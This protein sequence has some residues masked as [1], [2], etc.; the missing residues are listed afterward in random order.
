MTR[1]RI[2]NLILAMGI[3]GAAALG[4]GCAP[5]TLRLAPDHP[6]RPDAPAG[7]AADPA[8]I[9]G[10][11]AALYQAAGAAP[12]D[13][14]LGTPDGTREHPYVGR[15][16]IRE[17]REGFVVIQHGAIPGLMGAMTMTFPVAREVDGGRLVPGDEVRFFIEMREPGGPRIFRVE[18]I[19]ADATEQEDPHQ[20]DAPDS[21][22]TATGT[23][24]PG[25][26]SE[27]CARQAP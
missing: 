13:E 10:P 22:E 6:A 9:L 27:C 4:A 26:Q 25:R 14:P 2:F 11:N 15:G 7:V 8:S 17:I 23:E 19:E 5:T 24:S 20:H 21:Q 3:L 1:F 12:Q 16:I 18:E